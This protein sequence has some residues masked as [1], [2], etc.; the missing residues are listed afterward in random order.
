MITNAELWA[1]NSLTNGIKLAEQE[2]QRR[3]HARN[4]HVALLEAK[5]NA[6]F[7]PETGEF[8][9]KDGKGAVDE[10]MKQVEAKEKEK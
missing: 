9:P 8:A 10:A 7:N 5:Y 4:A 3:I 6:R 1:L 2:L